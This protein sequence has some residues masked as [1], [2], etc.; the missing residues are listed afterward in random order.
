MTDSAGAE[1][2]CDGWDTT[3]PQS[4]CRGNP[5]T[6]DQPAVHGSHVQSDIGE[7]RVSWDAPLIFSIKNIALRFAPYQYIPH[8]LSACFVFYFMD[9]LK[10]FNELCGVGQ[11]HFSVFFA[12]N[13]NMLIYLLLVGALRRVIWYKDTDCAQGGSTNFH[14]RPRCA[15]CPIPLSA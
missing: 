9:M 12:I 10:L 8:A 3:R 1:S 11:L 5:G 13:I 7:S 6:G 14:L 4:E 2:G 15:E